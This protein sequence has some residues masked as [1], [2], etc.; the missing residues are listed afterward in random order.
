MDAS[1]NGHASSAPDRSGHHENYDDYRVPPGWKKTVPRVLGA[2]GFLVMAI[3]WIWA[4][5]N[6]DSVPHPD[7]F[8]DPI[9]VE[10]AESLCA[11]RQAAIAEIPLATRAKDPIERAGLIDEG[12]EQLEL[13]LAE[14]AALKLPTDPKGA[15][16][17]PLWLDDYQLYIS[18]RERYVAILETGEDPPFLISANADGARVTDVLGTYAEV[19]NMISCSPSGDV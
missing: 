4:F 10:A 19:N 5:A 12:T 15:I 9:F 17:V 13:M 2:M 3:F 6:R 11:E 16:G 8:D 14:L 7:E 18:D 1:T